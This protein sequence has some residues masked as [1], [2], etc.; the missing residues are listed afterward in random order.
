MKAS[1]KY[2]IY[3]SAADCAYDGKDVSEFVAG[4]N[5]EEKEMFDSA[6]ELYKMRADRGEKC[7]IIEIPFGSSDDD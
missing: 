6:Y 1:R 5:E 7:P 4:L 2:S 3:L